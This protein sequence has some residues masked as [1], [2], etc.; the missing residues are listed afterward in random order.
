MIFG[1]ALTL[2]LLPA[3]R[4]F[5]GSVVIRALGFRRSQVLMLVL[6]EAIVLAL[7]GGVAGALGSFPFMWG[8]IGI[9]KHTPVAMFAYNLKIS[10]ATLL[11]AFTAA[12]GI[13]VLAGFVPAIRSSRI[14]I[15]DGLRRVA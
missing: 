15:V 10:L 4:L 2:L 12:V 3:W 9:I 5:Y 6:S 11:T 14:S 8:L 13:G 1:S 7:L